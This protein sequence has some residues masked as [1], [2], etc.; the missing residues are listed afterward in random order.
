[1]REINKGRFG[2]QKGRG[3]HFGEGKKI[4]SPPV[5]YYSNGNK[6]Q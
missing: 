1:M 4:L 5:E 3:I 6:G 2:K